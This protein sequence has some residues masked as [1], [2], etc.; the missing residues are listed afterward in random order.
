MAELTRQNQA[1]KRQLSQKVCFPFDT[2]GLMTK[3]N[4]E[5]ND[6]VNGRLN[7]YISEGGYGFGILI[8]TNQN[9]PVQFL[10]FLSTACPFAPHSHYPKE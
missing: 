8:I 9:K 4:T 1:L 5:D 7:T 3:A 10:M 6:C 2:K